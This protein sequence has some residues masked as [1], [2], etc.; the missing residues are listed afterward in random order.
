VTQLSTI[1]TVRRQNFKM[2]MNQ[3]QGVTLKK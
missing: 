2:A 3:D 1:S